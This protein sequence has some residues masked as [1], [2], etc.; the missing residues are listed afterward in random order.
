VETGAAASAPDG[1]T[2]PNLGGGITTGSS[3]DLLASYASFYD[4]NSSSGSIS[5]TLQIGRNGNETS[6]AS[7][8][9]YFGTNEST[10]T[11]S[12]IVTIN[13]TGSNLTQALSNVVV[14]AG[15]THLLIFVVNSDS[16]E[17]SVPLAIGFYDMPPSGYPS[18]P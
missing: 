1:Y 3:A 7:Y 10:K 6:I 16:T 17:E 4:T 15:A 2:M 13:K 18:A 8:R 11:G 14:P 9:V 5:G 12:A